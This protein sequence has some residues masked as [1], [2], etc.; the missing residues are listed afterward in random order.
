MTAPADLRATVVRLGPQYGR[1]AV[2]GLGATALHVMVYV[3]TIELAGMAP[4]TA[5][6]LGFAAGVN[7][8]FI[9]HRRWTFRGVA[10]D[11]RRSLLRFWVVA[12]AGF[13]LNAGFVQLVTGTFGLGYRWSLPLIVGVTPV[14]TFTLSRLWAF[15]T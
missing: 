13:V 2:V 11:A 15:R 10:A 4:P 9:G 6:A 1:F 8:S 14:L 12:L 5:N 7:L 3:A